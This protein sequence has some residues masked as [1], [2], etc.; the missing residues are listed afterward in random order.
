MFNPLNF[1]TRVSDESFWGGL[2]TVNVIVAY[3][4][5]LELY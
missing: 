4:V 3:L 2:V 1:M 5:Q